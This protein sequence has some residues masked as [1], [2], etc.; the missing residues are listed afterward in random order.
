MKNNNSYQNQGQRI[1]DEKPLLN[2]YCG[3]NPVE[4]VKSKAQTH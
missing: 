3:K 4:M 1:I 2:T